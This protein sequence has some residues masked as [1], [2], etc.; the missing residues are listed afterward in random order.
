MVPIY[1]QDLVILME[2]GYIYL[3]MAK[4]QEALEVFE[5]V[6]VLAPESEIPWVAAGTVHFARMNY[7]RALKSYKKALSLKADSPYARAYM[8]ETLFFKGRDAEAMKELEKASLLEPE[9]A[10]GDFARSLMDA[11]KKGFVPPGKIKSR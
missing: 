4:F 8:G 2:S 3:G 5:G 9:G 11:V 7:D 1:R 10:A 6:A